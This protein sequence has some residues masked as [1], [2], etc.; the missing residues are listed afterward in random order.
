MAIA[1]RTRTAYVYISP[2]ISYKYERVK[3]Y[4]FSE[5]DLEIHLEDG[6][7]QHDR[8]YVPRCEVHKL[9]IKWE[10]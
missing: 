4:G 9:E 2:D 7:G 3:W 1:A 6:M 10:F 5:T 8:I